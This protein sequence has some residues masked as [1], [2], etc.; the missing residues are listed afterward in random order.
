MPGA[1]DLTSVV[2]TAEIEDQFLITSS[3]VKV[4]P[5]LRGHSSGFA[6]RP[7]V[8]AGPC[9]PAGDPLVGDLEPAWLEPTD[10][11]IGLVGRHT[12]TARGSSSRRY[13]QP[14]F[15]RG[16]PGSTRY[17]VGR[18]VLGAVVR[19]ASLPGRWR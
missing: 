13:G 6:A 8:S 10:Q 11:G 1:R 3:L 9:G 5:S 18:C 2:I 16:C 19:S 4:R 14:V 17:S 7:A 15:L 12:K